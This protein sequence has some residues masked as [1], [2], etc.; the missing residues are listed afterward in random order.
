MGTLTAVSQP[1]G[2]AG[3]RFTAMAAASI[4]VVLAGFAGSCHLWPLTRATHS[5]RLAGVG[6][7]AHRVDPAKRE[8]RV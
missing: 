5:H 4:A 6:R 8:E 3:H 1:A 7:L 2:V